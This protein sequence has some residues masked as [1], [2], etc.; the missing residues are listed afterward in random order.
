[1]K[2]FEDQTSTGIDPKLIIQAEDSKA[3]ATV[4]FNDNI[5]LACHATDDYKR[6]RN[7][8]IPWYASLRSFNSVMRNSSDIR[9]LPEEHL[10]ELIRSF[11]FTDN[12][13]EISRENK[14]DFFYD[15]VNLYKIK[16]TPEAILRVLG[17]FGIP[18]VEL[19]EYW[20]Q[21]D[22][23]GSLVFRPEAIS[24]NIFS[25]KDIDFHTITNPDPHWML[26]ESQINQLFL[27]N[28]IAFPSKS[29][30]FSLK[31]ITQL[32]GNI[33]NPAIAI[34]SRLVQDQYADYISGTDPVKD[35]SLSVKML[36]SLLDLYL[37]ILYSFNLLY[38]KTNDSTDL[39]FLI[40]DGSMSLTNTQIFTLYDTITKRANST[41]K[42][43]LEANRDLYYN[44]FTR[45]RTTNFITD[46]DTAENVLTLTNIDL[47]NLIDTYN[48]AGDI[49]II[50]K[51]LIKDLN[52]YIKE[53]IIDL[54][55]NL[56]AS[57]FGFSSI[58]YITKVINFFKPYRAR[59]LLLEHI[60]LIDNPALDSELTDDNLETIKLTETIVDWDTANSTGCCC[61][62]TTIPCL[63][64][65]ASIY[66]SRNTFDCNSY[67]DIGA[68]IDE[69]DFGTRM[70][71]VQE[72]NIIYNYHQGD[73][74][75]C[76][77]AEFTGN[78]IYT[79]DIS[80]EVYYALQD[81]GFVDYDYNGIFDAPQISDVC[82]IYVLQDVFLTDELYNYLLTE[83]GELLIT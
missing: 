41:T 3:K 64:S 75:A 9:S 62:E 20:L 19:C 81:G 49:E 38:S 72:D 31:P 83:G 7:F 51:S 14:D 66:Y 30:Y 4:L 60:Y 5:D 23:T 61:P 70:G 45:L 21:Y 34:L 76:I 52:G 63:D 56:L 37:G 28:K 68:S 77:H 40:Y 13:E 22:S 82:Q 16:G 58:E 32:S 71:I 15:L 46:F 80:G 43:E 57:I 35:I 12:L 25:L 74:T 29:P 2:Y 69:E 54:A 10:N 50:L 24:P 26:T 17:F 27:N 42:T 44:N 79:G 6:L 1:M 39:S 11:G 55:P 65:T 47:K 48:S 59:L 33:I 73:A 67:Y 53:N 8:L 78:V 36:V 18:D